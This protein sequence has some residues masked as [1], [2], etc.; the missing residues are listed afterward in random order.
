MLTQE[1]KE[2]LEGYVKAGSKFL[3]EKFPNWR[4]K[5]W[6]ELDVSSSSKCPLSLSSGEYFDTATA[7]YGVSVENEVKYGFVMPSTFPTRDTYDYLKELWM[8]E[9][10]QVSKKVRVDDGSFFADKE[11]GI[12]VDRTQVMSIKVPASMAYAKVEDLKNRL[13][14]ILA[15]MS[16]ES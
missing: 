9:Y 7:K 3:D 6:T 14:A 15:E 10:N 2:T 4:D 13:E 12:T 1:Q 11:V 8:N 5:D 16:Q